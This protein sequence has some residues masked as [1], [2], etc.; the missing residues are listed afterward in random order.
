[1]AFSGSPADG[2]A[3][4]VGHLIPEPY[5]HAVTEMQA[6]VADVVQLSRETAR[7]KHELARYADELEQSNQELADSNR[8]IL[9]LHREL[10]DRA[11]RWRT[12]PRSSPASSPA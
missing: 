2:G 8:G 3:L 6:A 12:P 10:E 5:Q 4:L 1:M 11:S 7:Q 9:A